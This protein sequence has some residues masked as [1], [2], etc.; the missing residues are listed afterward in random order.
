MRQCYPC[1]P[2]KRLHGNMRL[3]KEPGGGIVQ[4]TWRLLGSFD[5]VLDRFQRRVGQNRNPCAAGRQLADGHKVI[6]SIIQG[7]MTP[8]EA[9]DT[10]QEGAK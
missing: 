9:M 8:Q 3:P 6:E 2:G 10:A 7:R 1:L 4:F 5:K